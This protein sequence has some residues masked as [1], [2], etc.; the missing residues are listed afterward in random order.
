[1]LAWREDTDLE[2]VCEGVNFR[3]VP[4]FRFQVPSERIPEAREWWIRFELPTWAVTLLHHETPH[5]LICCEEPTRAQFIN[6]ACR[7]ISEYELPRIWVR[8]RNR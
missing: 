6:H 1:M 3:L 7:L 4:M 2:L 5:K 8:E